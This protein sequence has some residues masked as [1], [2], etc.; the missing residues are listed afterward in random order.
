MYNK[1]HFTFSVSNMHGTWYHTFIS[2]PSSLKGLLVI[3]PI[4]AA[5]LSMEDL[6][7]L[8]LLRPVRAYSTQYRAS[9]IEPTRSKAQPSEEGLLMAGTALIVMLA[10]RTKKSLDLA[11]ARALIGFWVGLVYSAFAL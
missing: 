6:H 1:F 4:L 9:A 7:F 8:Q 5:P 11:V 10:L 3:F 2:P